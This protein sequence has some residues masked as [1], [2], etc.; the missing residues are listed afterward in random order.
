VLRADSRT[1]CSRASPPFSSP[2]SPPRRAAPNPQ[3]RINGL[4]YGMDNWIYGAYPKFGPP[5]RHV[6]EF[7]E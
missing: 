6:K 1:A 2:S 3:L 5:T 4:V 7:G